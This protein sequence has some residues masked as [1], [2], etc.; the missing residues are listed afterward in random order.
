MVVSRYG[1]ALI[2]L[3]AMGL[4]TALFRSDASSIELS[5]ERLGKVCTPLSNLRIC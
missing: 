5:V 4:C 1:A 3:L 2:A